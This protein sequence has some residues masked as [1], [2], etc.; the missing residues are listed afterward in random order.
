[1][2]QHDERICAAAP[3]NK[4][5]PPTGRREIH[6][7]LPPE[8]LRAIAAFL[9]PS[10][11]GAA[12][13]AWR[14]V[15]PAARAPPRRALRG[16][17]RADRGAAVARA[18]V[19]AADGG[20]TRSARSRRARRRVL[21]RQVAAAAAAAGGAR[22]HGVHAF[23][24][25]PECRAR[26]SARP[27]AA[28]SCS[29]AAVGD[30]R[31]ARRHPPRA[32]LVV[33]RAARAVGPPPPEPVAAAAL[34]PRRRAAR[35]RNND[36]CAMVRRAHLLKAFPRNF[37]ERPLHPSQVLFGGAGTAAP[38][39]GHLAVGAP[40]IAARRRRRR[41][42][43]RRRPPRR[44]YLEIAA[45]TGPRPAARSAHVCATWA[46]GRCRRCTAGSATTV[47]WRR[48]WC[49]PGDLSCDG[50]GRAAGGRELRTVARPHAR[51][52]AAASSATAAAP[53]RQDD[54][55]LTSDTCCAPIAHRHLGA[56]RA[57][58]RRRPADRRR[59]CLARRPRPVGS[60]VGAEFEFESAEPWVSRRRARRCPTR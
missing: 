45:T 54:S 36:R 23:M 28:A 31:H 24:E 12:A 13:P 39:F 50:A 8:L 37:P 3:D 33:P 57:S 42:P 44:V 55:L 4:C 20:C 19:A 1:M 46:G 35:G 40:P 10:D 59:R 6:P 58:R 25:P 2:D 17:A 34:L 9:V 14:G 51:T 32:R 15:R 16:A 43:P 48:H 60:R 52:T 11:F 29:A 53:L 18:V 21:R 49:R 22:R 5:T 7:S 56:R 38:P 30:G 26:A 41:R 27:V 47:R